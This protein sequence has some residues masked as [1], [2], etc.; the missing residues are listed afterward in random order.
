MFTMNIHQIWFDIG[1]G[2]KPPHYDRRRSFEIINQDARYELWSKS[3]AVRFMNTTCPHL[4]LLFDRLPYDINRCDLFRYILMYYKGGFYFDVD[5][6][7]LRP[8]C[9]LQSEHVLLCDE[10]PNSSVHET[11]H[12]GALYS[13]QFHLFWQFVFDEIHNRL[14]H[15]PPVGVM[16]K[17]GS[18]V[19]K[20][21]GTAMLRDVA[22]QTRGVKIANNEL[23]CPVR[24][25]NGDYLLPKDEDAVAVKYP[26]SACVLLPSVLTWRDI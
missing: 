15:L 24:A 12:N 7:C 25:I 22:I 26:T 2:V 16:M 3:E 9:H 8:L 14:R 11:V 18:E 1:H 4:L 6:K 23:F 20:L 19:L 21:T 17:K 10:W 13:P 5:F